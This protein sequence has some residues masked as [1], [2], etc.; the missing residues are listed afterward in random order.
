MLVKSTSSRIESDRSKV[1]IVAPTKEE[2]VN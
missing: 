2:P 1:S